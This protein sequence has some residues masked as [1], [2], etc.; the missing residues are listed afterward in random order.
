MP[1]LRALTDFMGVSPASQDTLEAAFGNVAKVGL[2]DWHT[3]DTTSVS[4]ESVERW[5]TAL[6]P[7]T[8]ARLV[9]RLEPLMSA[10]GYPLPK[11]KP[12]PHGDAAVRS[13]QLAKQFAQTLGRQG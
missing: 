2:G 3:Y 5:R 1:R 4:Q 11:L 7:S 9:P 13:Y 12:V 6:P 10:F 8:A